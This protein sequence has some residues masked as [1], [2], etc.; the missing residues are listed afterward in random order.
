MN[1]EIDNSQIDKNIIAA[2]DKIITI[3]RTQHWEITKKENLS[4]IQL[5]FIQFIS[6]NPREFCT[7]SKLA[8]EFELTKP[9]VSDSINNLVSKG[10]ISKTQSFQDA[11]IYFFELTE[12]SHD[13]L[14]KIK[15]T[16][17]EISKL[18]IQANIE[19]KIIITAFLQKLILH[20]Y[21]NGTLRQARTC[22]TC[23]NFVK[24]ANPISEK[25]HYCSFAK[26]Y[27]ADPELRTYCTIH[28]P[29]KKSLPAKTINT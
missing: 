2:L 12:K 21:N 27:M 5:Q 1:E 8:D 18:L 6:E 24:N 7:I 25:P 15:A 11:R 4:P 22:F 23:Y 14:N 3:Y 16:K 19:S 26:I 17:D 20:F 9:T 13:V 28:T 10:Y 29:K